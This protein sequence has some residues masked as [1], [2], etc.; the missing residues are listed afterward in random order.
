MSFTHDRCGP[1]VR[2]ACRAGDRGRPPPWHRPGHRRCPGQRAGPT[3]PA[4]ISPGP[5]PMRPSTAPAAATTSTRWPPS[6]A[7][8][9]VRAITLQAD[10]S[11]EAAVEAAVARAS[12]ELGT[13]TL[14][15][16]V[17][18]GSGP[19]FGARPAAQGAGRRVPPCAR[20][21]RGRHLAG[22]EGLRQ[23]HGGRRRGRAHLQ[24]VEPGRQAGLPVPR[25]LLRRQGGGDPAHPDHGPRARPLGHRRQRRL[26]RHGRHRPPQQGRTCSR[27]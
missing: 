19:G 16:N 14:V 1:P 8:H 26:P 9:D 24:R 2:G 15:A 18:G 23:P 22:L 20:R 17:A 13:V 3:W 12:E 7:E 25:R 27:T 5:T 11:D 4:S 10:V 21:Q 6:C